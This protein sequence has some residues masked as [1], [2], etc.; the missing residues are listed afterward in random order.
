MTARAA[1]VA[2]RSPTRLCEAGCRACGHPIASRCRNGYCSDVCRLRH[3][4]ARRASL[5]DR[6]LPDDPGRAE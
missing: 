3:Q 6:L 5:L 1:E 4:K 2:P